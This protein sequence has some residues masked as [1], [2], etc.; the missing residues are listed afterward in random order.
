MDF[1]KN[2][3]CSI[4]YHPEKANVLADGLSRKG[5]LAGLMAKE[6]NLLDNICEWNSRLEQ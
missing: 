2:Y 5:Q 1:L 4:N 6:W 3:E